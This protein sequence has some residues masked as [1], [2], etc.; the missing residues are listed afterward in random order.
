M[1]LLGCEQSSNL[2]AAML[3]LVLKSN[4]AQLLG[5]VERLALGSAARASDLVFDADMC[6]L[7]RVEVPRSAG[8]LQK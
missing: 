1:S 4:V 8:R 7:L 2:E 5:H 6:L 3:L